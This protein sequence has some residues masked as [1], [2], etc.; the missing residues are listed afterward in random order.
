MAI[1]ETLASRMIEYE[2]QTNSRLMKKTPVIIRLDGV[3]FSKFTKDLKKPFD[4]DFNRAMEY[5]CIKLKEKLDNVKM[6]YS[7]SD[8]I[9]ILLTDWDSTKQE[10]G[11]RIDTWYDYRLQKIVS[12]SASIAT[13]AF[14]EYIAKYLVV[15]DSKIWA[16]KMF[17]ARFDARAFNL[18][19]EEVTNYFIYRQCDARRNSKNSFARSFFSQKELSGLKSDEALNKVFI[20]KG[21]DWN[22]LSVTQ[23]QGFCI[24]KDLNE[25]SDKKWIIDE[26]I[27]DFRE[28]REYID[29][30]VR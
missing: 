18:P 20:E 1:K 27:P 7:Q 3:G 28:D 16:P 5:T 9:S 24:L 17:T 2:D 6:I 12:V 8:E 4:I 26:E 29:R 21:K 25:D 15:I 14:N 19:R 11:G 13:V 22:T 10:N 23:K 30:Y